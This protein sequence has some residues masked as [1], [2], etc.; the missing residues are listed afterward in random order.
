MRPWARLNDIKEIKD[1]HEHPNRPPPL[2]EELAGVA[3]QQDVQAH[4]KHV[5]K[6]M[7]ELQQQPRRL[8]R[9]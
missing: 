2:I 3:H 5:W 8:T 7:E 1:K 9:T 4:V 6:A